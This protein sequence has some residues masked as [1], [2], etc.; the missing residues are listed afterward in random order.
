MRWIAMSVGA[1]ALLIGG[2]PPAQAHGALTVKGAY[3]VQ[4]NGAVA[5]YFHL[6]NAGHEDVL[7]GVRSPAAKHAVLHDTVQATG[8]PRMVPRTE[9]E[10]PFL[11]DVIF[12]PGG[13]H[14]MLENL[15]APLGEGDRIP[16]TLLFE[17]NDALD[18]TVTVGKAAAAPGDGHGAHSSGESE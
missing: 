11:G 3:A 6:A 1:V 16:M 2:A 18:V 17:E 12:R 13:P 8:G 15:H 10:I 5:V 14:V 7:L 4:M 9:I